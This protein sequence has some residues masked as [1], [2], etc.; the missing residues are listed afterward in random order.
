[1]SRQLLH[2]QNRNLQ[3]ICHM[4][5]T[6]N[7]SVIKYLKGHLRC[8]SMI[9]RVIKRNSSVLAR[10]DGVFI[11]SVVVLL[12]KFIH[13]SRNPIF[14]EFQQIFRIRVL[15]IVDLW[16]FPSNGLAK[17]PRKFLTCPAVRLMAVE[18]T[19]EFPRSEHELL[20]VERDHKR[21]LE[22]PDPPERSNTR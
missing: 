7:Y 4:L 20:S 5:F 22:T 11:A 12:Q 8:A 17:K 1:M 16:Q 10:A 9:R 6:M 14:A 21:G 3:T 15:R 2:W 18:F 19:W 13:N